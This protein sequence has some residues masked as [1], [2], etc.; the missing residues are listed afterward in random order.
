[1]C[2]L[3]MGEGK[4]KNPRHKKKRSQSKRDR[5]CCTKGPPGKGAKSDC[6]T[7][8]GNNTRGAKLRRR[9]QNRIKG[10]MRELR[11]EKRAHFKQ[12]EGRG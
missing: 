8:W 9:D 3:Q 11:I 7:M 10:G 5:D 6:P 4:E 1:V 2:E 12:G